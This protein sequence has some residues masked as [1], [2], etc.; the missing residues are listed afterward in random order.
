MVVFANEKIPLVR[1]G[2]N[3]VFIGHGH[4]YP[5]IC[6]ECSLYLNPTCVPPPI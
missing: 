2:V 5:F 6:L 3:E 1:H 4:L